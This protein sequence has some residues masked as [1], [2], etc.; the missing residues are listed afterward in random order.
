MDKL[1]Y[2]HILFKYSNPD[3]KKI[4]NFE[5]E[6]KYFRDN[7]LKLKFLSLPKMKAIEQGVIGKEL[8]T[9]QRDLDIDMIDNTNTCFDFIQNIKDF[10]IGE[11]K[12]NKTLEKYGYKKECWCSFFDNKCSDCIK[13]IDLPENNK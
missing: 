4:S 11:L 13:L 5:S 12:T 8:T 10:F 1:Y 2:F 3:I 9:S 7:N 6:L